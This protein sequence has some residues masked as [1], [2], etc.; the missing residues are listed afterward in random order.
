[1]IFMV[2]VSFMIF[3]VQMMNWSRLK[4]RKKSSIL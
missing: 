2:V 4:V 3:T 1:M